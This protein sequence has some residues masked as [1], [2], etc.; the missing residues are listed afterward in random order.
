MRRKGGVEEL[1]D[2]A[3]VCS[4]GVQNRFKLKIVVEKSWKKILNI[5][6]GV[7]GRC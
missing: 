7:V 3:K 1:S 2:C 5:Q 4:K 6:A